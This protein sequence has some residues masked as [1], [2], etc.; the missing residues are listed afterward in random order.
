MSKSTHKKFIIVIGVYFSLT[1]VAVV[2][3]GGMQ[4]EP[5]LWETKS[6]VTSTVGVHENVS[7][8]CIDESEISPET[9]MDEAD[10]CEVTDSYV[11]ASSMQWTISCANQEVTMTGKGHAESSGNSLTGGMHVQAN[12]NDQIMTLDTTWEGNR[13]GDCE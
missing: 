11:D 9:M 2:T 1:I 7:Q 8:E 6:I 12:F 4:I 13:I 5:G 10:G 3:A